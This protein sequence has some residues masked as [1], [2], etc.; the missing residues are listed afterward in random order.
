MS[1]RSVL[2]SMPL[3][4]KPAEFVRYQLFLR[5][6]HKAEVLDADLPSDPNGIAVPPAK[7][8]HRV[9]GDLSRD[10]FLG[11]GQR[12]A[13][14]LRALTA[15][16]GRDWDSFS[17]VLDFGC[18]SARVVRD[19]L[20]GTKANYTGT[21]ID[22][23]LID[24]CTAKIPQVSWGVNPFMPPMSYADGAFDL[25]YSISVFTHL[26]EEFQNAWLGELHRVTRPG[27]ILILTV[28][29][30]PFIAKSQLSHSQSAE[31]E[32]NGF[33]F[34]TGTTGKRKLDG[35]PDFYQTAYHKKEYIQRVWGKHFEVLKQI[36]EGIGS[37]QDAL[38]LQRR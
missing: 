23:E 9:H 18:G 33:L 28:H 1:L 7:L 14:E 22:Q 3:F 5:Q 16:V 13:E 35:L 4:R 19:F 29:G 32:Q 25:V 27:A 34:V 11:V 21:D 20:K 24:W 26:N 30:E 37:V 10:N 36:P 2:K 6:L 12:V 15:S 17:D 38:V 31:L 8:R